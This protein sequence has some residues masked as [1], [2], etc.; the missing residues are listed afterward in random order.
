MQISGDLSWGVTAMH[1]KFSV[2]LKD[3]VFWFALT[4]GI[5]PLA[6]AGAVLV[7]L[8]VR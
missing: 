7:L 8:A 6:T 4:V 3:P 5:L 2:L 1:H